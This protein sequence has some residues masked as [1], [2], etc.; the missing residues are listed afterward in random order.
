MRR[1]TIAPI[2][3]AVLLAVAGTANAATKTDNMVVSATVSKNCTIDAP[4]L[5]FGSWDGDTDV[6]VNSNISVKCTSGTTFAV[7]L[8]TGSSGSYA[9]RTLVNGGDV[10][11]Y[12]LYTDTT[13]STVWG[14]GSGGTSNG[15]GSGAGMTAAQTLTVYGQ[16]L[17]SANPQAFGAGVYNDTITA[18]ITY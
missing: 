16:L 12:N 10:L 4:D 13:H 8:S 1:Q 18:T 17:A 9:S 14:N 7:D 2:A 11:N 3:A 6:A 5:N 15:T